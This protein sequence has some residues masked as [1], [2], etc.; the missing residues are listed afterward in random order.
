RADETRILGRGKES[1]KAFPYYLPGFGT[2]MR[3][4]EFEIL[5]REILILNS[6]N[7]EK[8][9][10]DHLLF[11]TSLPFKNS[12]SESLVVPVQCLLQVY[13]LYGIYN[14]IGFKGVVIQRFS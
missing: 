3:N 9:N 13:I 1:R 4:R 11:S 7:I 2:R 10:M 14:N 12:L 6:V 5:F 8:L